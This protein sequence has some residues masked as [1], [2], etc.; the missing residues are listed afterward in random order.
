MK[1]EKGMFVSHGGCS[2]YFEVAEVN[3]KFVICASREKQQNGDH[4]ELVFIENINQ[5][6]EKP[7]TRDW[8]KL[9]REKGFFDKFSPE[10]WQGHE[11]KVISMNEIC[12]GDRIMT[13][14]GVSTVVKKLSD[15]KFKLDGKQKTITADYCWLLISEEGLI[16]QAYHRNNIIH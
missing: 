11:A 4:T 7:L 10:G 3:E 2:I 16:G 8:I 12:I 15:R 6:V 5:C 14:S 9:N 13:K 1:I